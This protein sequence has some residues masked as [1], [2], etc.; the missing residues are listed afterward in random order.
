MWGATTLIFAMILMLGG[1]SIGGF[2]ALQNK[3]DSQRE[4][5]DREYREVIP[6]GTP[7][8]NR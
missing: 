1:L 8:I 7:A 3:P 6:G 2:K 5:I 4:S